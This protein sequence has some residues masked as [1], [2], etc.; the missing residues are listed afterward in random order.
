MSEANP[1]CVKCGGPHPFDTSL[2]SVMWNRV[3]RKQGHE[4]PDYLCATCI[5]D[6]F[7]KARQSF[8][9]RL[10][11]EGFH[12]LRIEVQIESRAALDAAAIQDENNG[13]RYSLGF[14]TGQLEKV[15][16]ELVLARSAGTRD[17]NLRLGEANR[18]LCKRV[19][20]LEA[21]RDAALSEVLRQ[22]AL[23]AAERARILRVITDRMAFIDTI[24][25]GNDRAERTVFHRKNE[26]QQLLDALEPRAEGEG[27]ATEPTK[28]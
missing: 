6:A 4:L 17:L 10:W 21:E 28:D 19:E 27:P 8:T 2:P 5:L 7:A 25:P 20:E 26:L 12:G 9:A 23:A 24:I 22:A 14:L 1:P 3:I 15:R 16:A 11:G 18:N 13:L